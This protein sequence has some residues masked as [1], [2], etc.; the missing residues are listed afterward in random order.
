MKEIDI[1]PLSFLK[2]ILIITG[3]M[4]S[5][6]YIYIN[7]D[8]KNQEQENLNNFFEDFPLN[9]DSKKEKEKDEKNKTK[10]KNYIAVIEIPKIK[11]L[12]GL[13]DKNSPLNNVNKNIEIINYSMPDKKNTN[14]VLAG[15]SGTSKVSYFNK[16]YKLSKNDIIYIYYNNKKYKYKVIKKYELPK[17]GKIPIFYNKKE[18]FLTLTTCSITINKQLLILARQVS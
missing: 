7:Y 16:I 14:L 15:H 17:N 9:T 13:Y 11:L 10:T 12:K 5:L 18:A 3:L 8:I 2:I 1:K 6:I 4:L